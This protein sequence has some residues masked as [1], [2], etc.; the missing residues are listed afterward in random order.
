[1]ALLH[2]LTFVSSNIRCF[3]LTFKRLTYSNIFISKGSTIFLHDPMTHGL[4]FY[5]L[6][7]L[8]QQLIL[9]FFISSEIFI[10]VIPFK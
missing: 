3:I 7:S 1:M 5:Q 8:T 6:M 4:R 10:N 2:V 9:S